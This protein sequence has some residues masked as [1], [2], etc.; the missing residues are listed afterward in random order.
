MIKGAFKNSCT[1]FVNRYRDKEKEGHILCG[2]PKETFL[3][4]VARF[5]K[6]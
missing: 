6:S 3:A 1:F 2:V 5:L 4:A